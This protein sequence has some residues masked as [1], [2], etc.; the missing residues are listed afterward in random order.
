MLRLIAAF[1]FS[2]ALTLVGVALAAFQLL[3][4]EIAA[5]VQGWVATLP[6]SSEQNVMEHIVGWTMGLAPHQV[7]GIGV[8]ALLYATLFLVEG[9]GLWRQKA[10]AEWLTVIA[11]GLPIPLE[12]WEV[13][14]H[15]SLF[16]IGALVVNSAVVWLLARHLRQKQTRA[17]APAIAR[18]PQAE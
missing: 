14:A 3:R 9:I 1:K 8:G 16:G 4:P 18:V 13:V 17:M 11:T 15:V 5:L 6:I 12:V 2:Q 7:L 10:W